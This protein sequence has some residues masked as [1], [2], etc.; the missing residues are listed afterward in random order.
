MSWLE[1]WTR[2]ESR[3]KVL[4]GA[5]TAAAVAAAGPTLAACAATS[6][7]TSTGSSASSASAAP[8]VGN[9]GTLVVFAPWHIVNFNQI[10][11]L[12]E[13]AIQPFVSQ[14]KGLR[15]QF[16]PNFGNGTDWIT[17]AL[18]GSAPDL[19]SEFQNGA[20]LGQNL[21]LDLSPY[22][23][24][25]N[26]DLSTLPTDRISAWTVNGGVYGIPSYTNQYGMMCNITAYNQ[27]GVSV[28]PKDTTWTYALAAEIWTRAAHTANGKRVAGGELLFYHSGGYLPE[29]NHL[30]AWGGEYVEPG[31]PAVCYAAST[32]TLAAANFLYPLEAQ[33]VA[34]A[35][36]GCFPNTLVSGASMMSIFGLCELIQ[37]A[38][39]VNGFDWD[40]W[41][42][43]HGPA[44][45]FTLAGPDSYIIPANT[46]V[47]DPT[48][49][50]LNWIM[51]DP[52]W[53]QFQI[54]S[55]LGAPVTKSFWS[56]Y[57]TAL[58]SVA[59][60]LAGKDLTVLGRLGTS[61]IPGIYRYDD[62]AAEA[63]EVTYG[64]QIQ[65]GT[66]VT[67]AFT[68]MAAQINALEVAKAK[69]ASSSA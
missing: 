3:R 13:E 26:L 44:G 36:G 68:A 31:N 51:T 23:S 64:A 42:M 32:N 11:P 41:P 48:F 35:S 28:P 5:A 29:A 10:A 67:Q 63:I 2:R 17:A 19:A 50:L 69:A 27:R 40:F 8:T 22:I 37:I 15:V 16:S 38:E 7:H 55:M 20:I 57:Y 39:Q 9:G 18:A 25:Y 12:F 43:P 6:G 47:A 24:K 30:A 66:S 14:N 59:P 61:H 4:Q 65:Q 46:K 53:Q 33:G 34:T 62:P 21:A 60:P 52:T 56:Y 58:A 49:Q 54:K 1:I 45:Q